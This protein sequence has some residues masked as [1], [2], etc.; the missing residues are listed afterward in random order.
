MLL[1]NLA[2]NLGLG[3]TMVVLLTACTNNGPFPNDL[4]SSEKECIQQK[5]EAFFIQHQYD[6]ERYAHL[7][8]DAIRQRIYNEARAYQDVLKRECVE[9]PRRQRGVPAT[10]TLQP[11]GQ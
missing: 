1:K 6:M 4:S 7:R 9:I 2:K 10:E 8:D 5:M 11:Q 3:T